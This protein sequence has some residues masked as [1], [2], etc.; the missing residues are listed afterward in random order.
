MNER[1]MISSIKGCRDRASKGKKLVDWRALD[2]SVASTAAEIELA[3][4]GN[5]LVGEH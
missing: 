1:G 3:R 2:R 4:A 5:L